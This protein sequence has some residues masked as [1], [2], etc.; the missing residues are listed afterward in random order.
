[1]KILL[2]HHFMPSFPFTFWIISIEKKI[3]FPLSLI[4]ISCITKFEKQVSLIN[5]VFPQLFL[6]VGMGC[7]R[8]KNFAVIGIFTSFKFCGNQIY[9]EEYFLTESVIKLLIFNSIIKDNYVC[10]VDFH[11]WS[12]WKCRTC[13]Y[14]LLTTKLVWNFLL[15]NT[16]T[17]FYEEWEMLDLFIVWIGWFRI[18]ITRV[19][20]SR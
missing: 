15:C 9:F 4:I 20:K 16:S 13:I 1:M 7:E 3:F 10:Q 14:P 18:L 19:K 12:F 2:I 11:Y 17:L 5:L 6:G 8:K